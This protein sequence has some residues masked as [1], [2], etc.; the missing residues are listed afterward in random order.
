MGLKI[1]KLQAT[2]VD[3]LKGFNSP[4]QLRGLETAAFLL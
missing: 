3:P 2:G 4:L 1:K